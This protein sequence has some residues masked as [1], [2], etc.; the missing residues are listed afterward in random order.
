MFIILPNTTSWKKIDHT[1]INSINVQLRKHN[2]VVSMTSTICDPIFLCHGVWSIDNKFLA[3]LVICRCCFH[4]HCVITIAKFCQAKTPYILKRVNT[5]G[6]INKDAFTSKF[7]NLPWNKSKFTIIAIWNKLHFVSLLSLYLFFFRL[8]SHNCLTCVN[9][10]DDQSGV[11]IFLRSSN[12]WSFI[13]SPVC[14]PA[15]GM[16]WTHN[17]TSSQLAC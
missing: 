16:I 11:R 10:C 13:C 12:I 6:L 2:D 1:L 8:Q 5:L 9:N 17:M 3:F 14:L 7:Y 4:L 15:M